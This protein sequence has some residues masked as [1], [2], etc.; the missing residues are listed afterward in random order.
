M[1]SEEKLGLSEGEWRLIEITI[2][3]VGVIVAILFMMN[4]WPIWKPHF[5]IKVMPSFGEINPGEEITSTISVEKAGIWPERWWY[6]SPVSLSTDHAEE[7]ISVQ[8]IPLYGTPAPTYI[9]KVVIHVSPNA[10]KCSRFITIVGLDE[11]QNKQTAGFNLQ[12]GRREGQIAPPLP[13]PIGISSPRN[14]FDISDYYYPS[15]WM[16]DIN[17]IWYNPASTNV[18]P[19]TGQSCI[20]IT[21]S[22]KDNDIAGWSGIYWQYPENNWGDTP[23]GYNLSEFSRLSFWARGRKGGEQAEFKV[24]GIK[25]GDYPDSLQPA[26]STQPLILT[27]EWKQ[28]AIDLKGK[29]LSRITGG[30]VWVSSRNEN[31]DGC[32]I[33]LD[34]IQFEK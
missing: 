10:T 16:G 24:G 34:S 23:G 11:N 3:I 2:G 20:Q 15:G 14:T 32:T 30:F 7:G 17:D 31:P 4:V 29:D 8:F 25:E 22:P 27:T 21:Y 12:I 18:I 28:Y 33:Y 6:Q 13:T 19:H 26:A 1:E 5:E 9:S